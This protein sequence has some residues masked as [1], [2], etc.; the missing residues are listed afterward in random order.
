MT[1]RGKFGFWLIVI[2]VV[3]A[4]LV[5][6]FMES[7]VV[8]A[9]FESYSE[10]V[11]A[12]QGSDEEDDD[13]ESEPVENMQVRI[14]DEIGEYAGIKTYELTST[15]FFPE[16]KAQAKVIDISS[17]LELQARHNQAVSAFNVAKVAEQSA[18]H[19][20]SRLKKLAKGTGSVAAKNVHYAQATYNGEKAKLQGLNFEIRAV[21]DETKQLW[22]DTISAWV[23][24][25]NSKIWKRLLSHQDSLVLLT[26][27]VDLSLPS[28]DGFIRL[29]R[30]GLRDNARK[31]YFVSSALTT[32]QEVQGETYFYK[33]AT[34][35]LRVGMRLDAWLPQ[36]EQALK[37]V[38]IPENAIV[39]NSGQPWVYILLEEDLYQRRSVSTGITAAGGLFMQDDIEAG[40]QLVIR[41]TQMLLSEEFR[42]QILD[43]DDD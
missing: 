26:L 33:T 12:A 10:A 30:D 5:P 6:K 41:G 25:A 7:S 23:L 39:W 13:D 29:A 38:F 19:E 20:L 11:E 35:N 4:F 28:E 31:A 34:G 21:R 32:Q 37:G 9:W 42:W 18:L 24:D 8:D 22:G 15:E 14:D 16:V 43:E 27:P 40:E 17:M 3:A 36:G 1:L 2:V